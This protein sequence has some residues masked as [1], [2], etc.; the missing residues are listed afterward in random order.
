MIT[1]DIELKR[2][3]DCVIIRLHRTPT[4][5]NQMQSFFTAHQN[6]L[7]E[8]KVDKSVRLFFDI[9]NLTFD[10]FTMKYIP[11]IL[12]HFLDC[13][14]L[15]NKKLKVCSVWVGSAFAASVIQPLLDAN[16]GEVPTL[17]SPE[18]AKCKNFLRSHK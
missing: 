1:D 7:E 17:I 5:P 13:Q 11:P 4:D 2:Q 10:P 8:T 18:E 3:G 15:S 12:K 6:M 9:Y 16:P 14:Y